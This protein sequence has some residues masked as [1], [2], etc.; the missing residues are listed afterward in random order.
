MGWPAPRRKQAG[1]PFVTDNGN[2]II[3]VQIPDIANPAS[4]ESSLLSLPGVLECGLF[5]QMASLVITGTDQGIRL[6]QASD[7]PTQ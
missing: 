7:I 3:D 2:Y 6:T 1:Q 4:L 5:V